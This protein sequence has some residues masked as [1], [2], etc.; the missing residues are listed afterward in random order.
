MLTR[1]KGFTITELL[2]VVAII[3]ILTALLIPNVIA[4]LQ[5]AKQKQTMR[6]IFTIATAAT[7]Y[8]SDHGQAPDSGNQD[9]PL[10]TGC[11]FIR[12]ISPL[13]IT[14]CPINDQW[15]NAFQVHTGNAVAGIFGIQST[16]IGA[17]DV[18][19]YSY[20]RDQQLGPESFSFDRSDPEQGL[21]Q[22]RAIEHFKYD[23]INWNG[24]WIHA[25][26]KTESSS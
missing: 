4:A 16:D 8:A 13:Y 9:G 15:E 19:V 14:V 11:Q 3:G 1:S 21:Y 24:S 10:T 25:P 5:K 20:G 12:D 17:A 22:I 18:L 23:L 26:R 6:D 7:D 2:I